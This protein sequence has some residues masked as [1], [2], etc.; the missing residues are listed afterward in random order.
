MRVDSRGRLVVEEGSLEVETALGRRARRVD[1]GEA[2]EGAALPDRPCR[3]GRGAAW[4]DRE[5]VR[6]Y[7]ALARCS[8]GR[9]A[10]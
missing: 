1:L 4:K 6:F 9:L 2:V 7:K 3:R 8:A 5:T 10:E